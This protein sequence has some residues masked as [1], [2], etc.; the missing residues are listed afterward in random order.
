MLKK[1]MKY[2]YIFIQTHSYNRRVSCLIRW[3][4][5]EQKRKKGK[6]EKEKKCKHK[7]RN[8]IESSSV[9]KKKKKLSFSRVKELCF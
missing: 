8:K 7:S 2:E 5:N 3:F 6:R 4:N 1:L 9:H